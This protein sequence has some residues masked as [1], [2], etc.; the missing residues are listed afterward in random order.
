MHPD[1]RD[2]GRRQGRLRRLAV[3]TVGSSSV[4]SAVPSAF[5]GGKLL[6]YTGNGGINEGYA[7]FANAAGRTVTTV[8]GPPA[9]GR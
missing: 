9:H 7:N 1:R 2:A 4:L 5:A 6:V 8:A 3:I